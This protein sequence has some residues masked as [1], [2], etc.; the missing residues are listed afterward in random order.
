MGLFAFVICIGAPTAV[1]NMIK[2]LQC[3]YNKNALT[4][5]MF[6]REGPRK[7]IYTKLSMEM[8]AE[9]QINI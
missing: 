5:E 4:A 2:K 8:I 6:E 9:T 7:P 1:T 3:K